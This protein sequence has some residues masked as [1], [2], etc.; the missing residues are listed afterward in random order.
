MNFIV[1]K[2]SK[3]AI[4]M[5]NMSIT[6]IIRNAN[7]DIKISIKEIKRL[8]IITENDLSYANS[9]IYYSDNIDIINTLSLK[10]LRV[11]MKNGNLKYL[12]DYNVKDTKNLLIERFK[13]TR[14]S[15]ANIGQNTSYFTD[16]YKCNDK[17]IC[18][19]NNLTLGLY[20]NDRMQLLFVIYLS[21]FWMIIIIQ[22]KELIMYFVSIP[23]K[24]HPNIDN[25]IF[26]QRKIIGT[27]IAKH[28]ITPKF[29]TILRFIL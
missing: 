12:Y 8:N 3:K 18:I 20:Q 27:K 10:Q 29:P 17:W 15:L 26:P 11:I 16:V 2:S 28:K 23:T 24:Y 6:P 14:L 22:L 13:N 4:N 25:S 19:V 5:S 1:K 9:V 7:L 21:V